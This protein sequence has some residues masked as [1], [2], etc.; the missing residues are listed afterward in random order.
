MSEIFE[1]TVELQDGAGNTTILLESDSGG[2]GQGGNIHVRDAAGVARIMLDSEGSIVSRDASAV[3]ILTISGDGQIFIRRTL[4]T[5]YYSVFEFLSPQAKLSIGGELTPGTLNLRNGDGD[6]AVVLDANGDMT[7][8]QN[9]GGTLRDVMTFNGATAAL[10]VGCEDNEG[11]VIVKDGAGRDAI[12]LDGNLAAI[13]VGTEG[14]EGDVIV[15]DGAGNQ[16]IRLDGNTAAVF[17]GTE[18]NEGDV[19][20]YDGEGRQVIHL[21][22]D[23]AVIDVGAEGNEGDV[24]VY[25]ADGDL[26]IHLDGAS[27][28]VNTLGADCAEDFTV[29]DAAAISPGTVLVIDDTGGLRASRTAYDRRVAGV[30]SGAGSFGPGIVLD[31]Q[32]DSTDRKPVAL[33]GKVYCK[34]DAECGAVAVGD[35]LTTADTPGHAMKVTDPQRAFGAVIGKALA[36]LATGQGLIPILVG[37]H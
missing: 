17:V 3:S 32:S 34:V 4:G 9:I 7:F 6:D 35:L 30:V 36:P 25:D 2:L 37:L 26:R 12:H 23:K 13:H 15:Y 27:G 22:G 24:R 1:G 11:D 16:A 29:A 33:I 20:V 5:N 19:I 10:N 8:R 31:R 21:G 14:N 18:G 28:Q